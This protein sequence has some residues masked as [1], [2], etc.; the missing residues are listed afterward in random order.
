MNAVEPLLPADFQALFD[1]SP[2]VL[3]VMR[4]EAPYPFLAVNAAFLRVT[5]TQRDAVL[6]RGLFEVF[7]ANPDSPTTH[8]MPD[9]LG[10]LGRICRTGQ[11]ELIPPYRYDIPR[12]AEAGGGFE[13]RFWQMKIDPASFS[14]EREVRL[15]LGRSED[16]TAKVREATLA[17]A[18]I[19]TWIWDVEHDRVFAD[20]NL[21]RFFDVSPT[22]AEG[23]PL[24]HYKTAIHEDDRERV[25][26]AIGQAAR[27]CAG[28][29][30]EYRL[31]HPDR[32]ERWVHARGWAECDETGH[33]RR[34]PGVV[35]DITARK[36]AE[37]ALHENAERLRMAIESANL[38]TWDYFPA[39]GELICSDLCH[40][41]LGLPPGV[42]AT[43]AIFMDA[44]HHDDREKTQ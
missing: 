12:P 35:L 4:A 38:G 16:I 9:V 6:G 26:T 23:G 20:R 18:E 28:Y 25:S 36:R 1:N 3:F 19:G 29:E 10:T 44:L 15:L 42:A 13:E 14:D 22:D 39:T 11:G 30:I 17:A 33:V 40:A 27:D 41:M 37:D 24:E 32:P 21:A 8:N 31:A 7:P 43:M 2:E 34:F 5:M